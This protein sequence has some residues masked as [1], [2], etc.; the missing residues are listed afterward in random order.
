[1]ADGVRLGILRYLYNIPSLT[2][3]AYIGF[4][5]AKGD[6]PDLFGLARGYEI[7]VVEVLESA[8]ALASIEIP[9]RAFSRKIAPSPA[10]PVP[11]SNVR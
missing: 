10:A 9:F 7:A 2:L 8:E 5:A 11:Q 1:M 3:M 4:V 6:V